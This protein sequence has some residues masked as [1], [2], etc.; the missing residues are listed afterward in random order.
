VP[1]LWLACLDVH[2][3][4]VEGSVRGVISRAIMF[5]RWRDWIGAVLLPYWISIVRHPIHQMPIPHDSRANYLPNLIAGMNYFI[6]PYG[7]LLLA[8]PFIVS[9]VLPSGAC[10]H[11]YSASGSRLCWPWADHP[12]AEMVAGTRI[13]HSHLRAFTLWAALL[14][15]PLVG[16][17]AAELLDRFQNKAAVGL[18]LAA[19]AT[20]G[21]ALTWL[22]LNPFHP[23]LGAEC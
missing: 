1:V 7:V 16:L 21:L 6:V 23:Q 8:F 9:L 15:L 13:R 5:A 20:F 10:G 4:R 12:S 3:Q 14:A 22:N 17:L 18:A 19:V 11:C 2:E